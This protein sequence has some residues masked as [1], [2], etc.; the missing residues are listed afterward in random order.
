MRRFFVV[1]F[2]CFSS[3]IVAQKHKDGN[4]GNSFITHKVVQGESL[5]G[6]ARKYNIDVKTIASS[7]NFPADKGLVVGQT[8]KIPAHTASSKGANHIAIETSNSNRH[9][10]NKGE[11]LFSIANKH[12]VSMEDLQRWNNLTST[13]IAA[14]TSLI[15]AGSEVDSNHVASSNIANSATI[16]GVVKNVSNSDNQSAVAKKDEPAV[17]ELKPIEKKEEASTQQV[18]TPVIKNETAIEG[19][20]TTSS[21]DPSNQQINAELKRDEKKIDLLTPEPET[22]TEGVFAESYSLEATEKSLTNKTGEAATFKT[23]SGWQDKKYYVLINKVA[24]GTILKIASSD[25]K[26]IFAKVLGSMPEMKENK[27][28]L[29]RVSNAAAAYLGMID[30]KF[31]VQ[32]S[33]YQ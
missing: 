14:G 18:E 29:L 4:T 27:G 22:S 6:L 25:N 10:V 5:Y 24:P 16:P 3:V 26:V 19:K 7:N 2:I 23:T 15:L 13:N 31:P 20:P 32:V 8:I 30:P 17:A 12:N 33:F 28:L 21:N 1:C 9:I 11:T